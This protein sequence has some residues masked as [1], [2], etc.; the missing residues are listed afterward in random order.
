VVGGPISHID[1]SVDLDPF[2]PLADLRDALVD[3]VAR[4]GL[5]TPSEA[6]LVIAGDQ[7]RRPLA[8]ELSV[9]DAGVLSGHVVDIVERVSLHRASAGGTPTTQ[10]ERTVALDVT[11][12]PEAGRTI[13]LGPGRHT[14]GRA[15]ECDITLAD[16][17][18]SRQHFAIEVSPSLDVVVD[19]NP[20]ATNGTFLATEHLDGP[21]PLRPEEAFF[22]G[23]SQLVVRGARFDTIGQRDRLGQVSFNRLPYR[24]PIVRERKLD[25][26]ERPPER[27]GRRRFHMATLLIPIIGAVLFVY[28]TKRV[29]FLLL[30][31]LSP[32]MMVSNHVSEGRSSKAN[33]ARDKAEFLKRVEARLVDVDAALGAERQERVTA[34]PDI[35]LLARQAS[36]RLGR[37]WERP[38]N[39]PD[40]L[41]LR[42]GLGAQPTRISTP[43]EAGGDPELRDLATE[44][45]AR[46][47]R[48]ALVPVTVP[49]DELGVTGLFGATEP[50]GAL[51]T[52]LIMQA[53]TLHSPED[54]VV[55]AAIPAEATA[56]WSWLKWLPHS[57]SV[58]SPVEGPQ[59][60]DE[61]GVDDLIRHLLGVVADRSTEDRVAGTPWP[62]V[63]FVLHEGAHANRALLATLLDA[64]AP[65]GIVTVWIGEEDS[66]LPRHCRATI[67]CVSPVEGP[68]L[69]RFT[70]PQL[71]D[72]T[73]ELEGITAATADA[74][75]RTLAPA[76]DVSAATLTTG[77]PRL[78]N[79]LD[80]PGLP[81]PDAQA[82]ASNWSVSRPYRL[83]ATIGM[84]ADGPLS[85]DL[86]SEGP[87]ALIAG[88][89]G[90]GKS[91]LLQTLVLAL[92]TRYPPE[93]LNF[94][95]ID[96]KG[97]AASSQFAPLPH[98]VGSV[99]NLD[100]RLALRAL[101]SLQ[102]ELR[103]RMGVLEGRAKDLA[104][105]LEVAPAEAPPS[106]VIV[107]DEFATLVKE[108]PDFMAGMVDVAQRGRSLGIHLVLATQRP[109]GAVNDNILANT[110]LR[111]ALRVLDTADSRA[112]IDS[113]DAAGIP[114]P[115]RGRAYAR[116]GPGALAP[117]QCA[118]AGAP[119]LPEEQ[120]SPVI[121]HPYPFSQPAIDE[122]R[123]TAA[124][125]DEMGER[126][127]TQLAVMVRACRSAAELIGAPAPR[128]PWVEPLPEG[129]SLEQLLADDERRQTLRRADPGRYA[130]L[131]L[132]DLPEQQRQLVV[133]IDLEAE[134][135]L[136][137]FG[138][139][140]SGKTTLLR[141]IAADLAQQGSPDQVRL[142]VLDFSGRSMTQLEEL[143]HVAA[144]AAGD[145]LEHVTRMITVLRLELERRRRLLADARV[146]SVSALRA[147]RGA[148]SL[149]RLVVLLDSYAGFHATFEVGTYFSWILQL[150]QLVAE[151]RQVGIHVIMATSRQLGVPTAL[152]SAI[153][154]RV[155]LRMATP[156]ELIGLGVARQAAHGA[157]LRPGRGFVHGSV[158]LQVATVS[159]DPSG[160]AQAA[161]VTALADRLKAEGVRLANALKALPEM[162]KLDT[163]K[164]K[165]MRTGPLQVPLGIADLTLETVHVDLS[166]QNL[167]VLGPPMSG[168][169]TALG[170]VAWALGEQADDIVLVG[171]GSF[172]SP[173]ADFT[174]WH[175]AGFGRTRH[176]AVLDEVAAMIEGDEGDEV[177]LVL[178]LDAV[179]D[180]EAMEYSMR[181]EQLVRSD[182]VRVVATAEA[183]TLERAYSGWTAEL[184]RNRAV[185]MLQPESA[186]DV[187]AVTRAKPSLRPGQQFPPG[188]GVLV[189]HG[190]PTLIQVAYVL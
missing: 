18:M 71:D 105:M 42:L 108:I 75:A 185:L 50:V 114:V 90:A 44:Q 178:V 155:V 179:E 40:F 46:H 169:S 147:K 59:L 83:D 133:D 89:S 171:L 112:V 145:D 8:P 11:S 82:I 113:K 106:L 13:V 36:G 183:V 177:K 86:V 127:Q 57:R 170:A 181:L 164:L 48:L 110:N 154:A 7:Q 101:A 123:S 54:L 62:R 172:T 93:R 118:W 117:F 150:Q 186:A 135:G 30:A 176:Q 95:F 34:A 129:L 39:S 26:L 10:P 134:G 23:S 66:Q 98:T 121:V 70:D 87:H 152:T 4:H 52:S 151:G 84:G 137:I 45:L 29:E 175:R 61:D 17:S 119:F 47:R 158:E 182:A 168:R 22:A 122:A 187:E 160:S 103:R 131:G 74:M 37:L 190:R 25:P 124:N 76:R 130:V 77:I 69:L 5:P 140:G 12:G 58:T 41:E 163:Q 31:G 104:E 139:G 27:P 49:L 189:D 63:L 161:A 166:R 24:R 149:P 102:A 162:V 28:L 81:G 180:L 38:R 6:V 143:P 165:K 107:V 3:W 88:T 14:V 115:L 19:P 56:R 128:R 43:I 157:E 68:S 138:A 94:L 188:R 2:T 153:A 85:L 100:E 120:A 167:V 99:T 20:A 67:R 1:V 9:F 96:Y 142:Y 97:G 21:R 15:P 146:E 91:E 109:T 79:L 184:K 32:L 73:F 116:T 64:A 51:G 33:Y 55:T 92:A 16:P 111:I 60:V 132:G 156:D 159:E 144:A 174:C 136:L 148:P 78:V 141:T 126:A 72:Q 65:A 125:A 80:L 173:L 35:P 53:A